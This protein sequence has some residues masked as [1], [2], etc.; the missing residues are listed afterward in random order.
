[1]DHL[2]PAHL[3]ERI[4]WVTQ[5][6]EKPSGE[7]VIYWMHHAVRGHENPA[8]DVAIRFADHLGLPLLVYHAIC[9]EYPFASDRHHAFMLQG[10]RDVQRDL[11]KQGIAYTFHLQREGHRGPHLRD[12][13]R[14]AALVISDEMPLAPIQGWMERLISVALTPIVTVD[15]SCIV[16]APLLKRAYTRAFEFRSA[17]K[18]HLAI[19]LT[20]P[21]EPTPV[22]CRRFQGDLPYEPVD[23]QDADLR[24]L[25]ALCKIDHTVAPVADTPGGSRAGYAR[26]EEFKANRLKNYAKRRNDAADHKGVSR[27]SAYLHYGMVS[28][29]R[30]AREAAEEGAEK[31]LDELL[32]WRE[33][34]FHYCFHHCDEVN[35][36]EAIPDW[37]MATLRKHASDDR[38]ADHSWETLSRGKTNQRLWDA[39]Q[40]SLYKHGEL[41]NNVRMTWGKA[42]LNWTDSPARSLQ[43]AIDLNHRYA[44]DG[45]DPSSYGGLLWCFGQFDRPFEPEVPVFGTVRPRELEVHEKRL[46]MTKYLRIVDRPI[47]ANPP[48][49]AI[50]G[51]GLAGLVAARTL[52]DYGLSVKL[53]D[54]SRG[55]GGRMATRRTPDNLS[56]DHGAQYFTAR[57]E[58]F[59][60]HVQAWVHDGIVQQWQGRVVQLDQGNVVAEKSDTPRYVGVPAMNSIA[61]FLASGLDVTLSTTVKQLRPIEG[62]SKT[63]WQLIDDQDEIKG[64]FDIVLVN[65]PP[66]QAEALLKGHTPM[67]ESFAHLRMQPCWASMIKLPANCKL[68]YDAAFVHSS[69]LSWICRN[70]TKPGRVASE[71]PCWVLHA[72]PSW[73]EDNLE[74]TPAEV[75]PRLHQAFADAVG[76]P[77]SQIIP[78]GTHRWRYAI[79]NAVLH[80]PSLWDAT[81]KLGACGDWCGGPRVEGAYLSGAAMAGHVLREVTIDRRV[82]V[83][84]PAEPTLF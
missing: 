56:F 26:W 15:T 52:V 71:E 44:L 79:P 29:F 25:I 27:M 14:R 58:R 63:T 69:P 65:C 77:V 62:H 22:T 16:P 57:D 28:P 84:A 20:R 41:H 10:A 78:C 68:P 43:M 17:T 2:L 7:F 70:D 76:V 75:E 19:R 33:L 39:C 55:V 83:Q 36:F 73:S 61:R 46:D 48:R 8:L 80:T 12:L 11:S 81:M 51:A 6:S 40:R 5:P 30:I 21:Y 24:R 49:I 59:T 53:F 42:F 64:E 66:P 47:C 38:D 74:L 32:V 50:V 54:K 23:L 82:T 35:S 31:F 3:Q 34:A 18:K 45:R 60:K 9:E 72:S 37:A 13:A 67:T 4:R 1:M